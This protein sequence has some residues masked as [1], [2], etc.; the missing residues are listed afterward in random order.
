MASTA[1]GSGSHPRLQMPCPVH[2]STFDVI[3][4]HP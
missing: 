3:E 4:L 2:E 1:F